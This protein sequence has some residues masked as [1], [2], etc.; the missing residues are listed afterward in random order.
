MQP[1]GALRPKGREP[2]P[3]WGDWPAGLLPKGDATWAFF[4]CIQAVDTW[5]HVEVYKHD[6][7]LVSFL[8]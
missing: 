8:S 1:S 5:E 6:N 4:S 3:S 2:S 7:R